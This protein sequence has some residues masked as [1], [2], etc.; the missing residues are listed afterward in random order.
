MRAVGEKR[1]EY[2]DET[3][4]VELGET[5][6]ILRRIIGDSD[7]PFIYERLGTYLDHFLIDE[8][9]GHQPDAV[10]QSPAAP[11]REHVARQ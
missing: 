3:N 1:R 5:S 11:V 7:T 10:A 2:L 9:P 6:S 8:F 4:S